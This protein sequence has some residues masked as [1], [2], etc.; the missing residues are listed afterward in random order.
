MVIVVPWLSRVYVICILSA[1]LCI[2]KGEARGN[3]QN[4]MKGT[5]HIHPRSHGTAD[6]YHSAPLIA[7]RVYTVLKRTPQLLWSSHVP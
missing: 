4:C 3:T 6:L 2:P 1:V 5:N 7:N